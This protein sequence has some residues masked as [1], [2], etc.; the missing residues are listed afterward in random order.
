MQDRTQAGIL[1]IFYVAALAFAAEPARADNAVFVPDHSTIPV[2]VTK[3]IRIGGAGAAQ[4]RDVELEVASDVVV[5]GYLVAKRGDTVIAHYATAVNVTQR[6]F[7]QSV[8]QQLVL[9]VERAINYCGDTLH[10][11]F[12]RTYTGGVEQS[13][14][15]IVPHVHDIVIPTGTIF[16]AQTDRA[17]KNVCAEPTAETP[18]LPSGMISPDEATAA[19][20]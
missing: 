2:I 6:V 9:D 7:S 12:E 11:R 16:A 15:T 14:A 18:A 5:D 3:E 8:Q 1:G 4:Q 13:V 17:E 20:P 19:G 10:L